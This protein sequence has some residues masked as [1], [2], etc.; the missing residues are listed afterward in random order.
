MPL[1]WGDVKGSFVQLSIKGWRTLT[2][3]LAPK[4][5]GRTLRGEYPDRVPRGGSHAHRSVWAPYVVFGLPAA[6]VC[7]KDQT[8]GDVPIQ[9]P[10]FKMTVVY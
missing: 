5:V 7:F 10:I 8:H 2:A 1:I 6:F 9:T 3:S 4:S